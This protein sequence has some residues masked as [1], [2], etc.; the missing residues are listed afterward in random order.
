[1]KRIVIVGLLMTGIASSALAQ[2][3]VS[4]SDYWEPDQPEAIAALHYG[5]KES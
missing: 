4:K 3:E 2:I 5:S 1:V